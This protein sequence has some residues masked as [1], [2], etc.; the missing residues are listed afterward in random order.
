MAA[1]SRAALNSAR[2]GLDDVAW[3]DFYS[4]F[5]VAVATAVETLGLR[6]DDPRGVTVTGGL[7]YAGG[8]ANNYTTHSIAA[9]TERLRDDPGALGVVSAL[10]WFVTK[11]GWAVYGS[12]P[13]GHEVLAPDRDALQKAV[14]AAAAARPLVDDPSGPATVAA[15]TVVHDRSGAP[16]RGMLI[17]ETPDGRRFWAE[18]DPD[19]TV[20]AHACEHE[21]VG[22]RGSVRRVDG[23]NRF[24]P[25]E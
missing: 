18:L 24:S 10:G 3:F 25:G 7:P 1:A 14:D 5:P 22:A 15:Y 12:R 20:L 16:Q 9:M 6:P 23:R 17:G 8:P 21:L 4:C 2:V 19:P 13:P 11:H